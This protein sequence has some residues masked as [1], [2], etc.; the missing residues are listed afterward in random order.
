M[1]MPKP[2]QW[3]SFSL[4]V[5]IATACQRQPS[6]KA[7]NQLDSNRS[8]ASD[9]TPQSS[10]TPTNDRPSIDE[11][12]IKAAGQ[13][14]ALDYTALLKDAAG[15]TLDDAI[16]GARVTPLASGHTL[17]SY[18]GGL[19]RLDQQG[20]TIWSYPG[21]MVLI[22]YTYVPAN[23]LIYGTAVDNF[24]FILDARSGKELY[25]ISRNGSASYGETIPYGTDGC[26][27][28]EP[29][30][31]YRE[32]HSSFG[33]LVMDKPEAWRGLKRL[34][35][36]EIPPEAKISVVGG[37]IFATTKTDNAIYVKEIHPPK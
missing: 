29:R 32:R 7:E 24:M 13:H 21:L 11:Q 3:L 27:I 16:A 30:G 37:K 22:S 25:R 12:V 18:A 26:L 19:F 14:L 10:A 5:V 2:L 17:I 31:E 35:E 36:I 15:E 34:W 6:V 28:V 23:N 8:A 20:K 33:L 1:N 4:L 9:M